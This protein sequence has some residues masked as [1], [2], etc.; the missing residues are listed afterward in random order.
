ML[1]CVETG[2]K[3]KTMTKN[4]KHDHSSRSHTIIRVGL[5]M[6][7]TS[8]ALDRVT[9]ATMMLVDLAGSEA[10]H[11]NESKEGKS[12]GGSRLKLCR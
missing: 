7:D 12:E 6:R 10:A 8:L 9:V 11:K 2:M 4:Y 5:E 3:G 1:K